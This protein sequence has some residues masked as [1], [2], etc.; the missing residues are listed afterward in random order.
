VVV[1]GFQDIISNDLQAA[2]K[3]TTSGKFANATTNFKAIL[4]SVLLTVV[5][6][7]SE[8]DEVQQ[9]IGVCREY[10]LGLSIEQSR[11][12]VSAENPDNI[13][14]ALE[15]SAYFTHCQLQ[16]AHLQLALRQGMKLSFKVKNFSTASMFARRLLELAPPQTVA[17]EA[18]Q[19]QQVA[20]RT[21]RD[22]F[23]LDYDSYNPFVVCAASYTPIYKGSPSINCP[24]CQTS[25][26]PE[27]ESTQ[28]TVCEIA[29]VGANASGLRVMI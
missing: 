20:E 25:Y 21:P 28:C 16:P 4:H 10:I 17:N 23:K 26:K 15:L 27:Y 5:S 2:Y 9:L 6:K 22:E 29:Q 18:R 12:T 14:R 19:I 3:L 13:K 8:V 7:K 11:R 24:Y 1:Y